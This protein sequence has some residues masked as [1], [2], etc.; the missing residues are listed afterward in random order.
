M[1]LLL[2][3]AL[4]T[5]VLCFFFLFSSFL[6]LPF[7]SS[8]SS[9][10]SSS[11]F[12]LPLLPPPFSSFLPHS[13]STPSSS[14]Q[15]LHLFLFFILSIPC[16]LCFMYAI[17][18]LS[19]SA[20]ISYGRDFFPL[21]YFF[22]SYFTFL[23]SCLVLFRFIFLFGSFAVIFIWSLSS[24]LSFRLSLTLTLTFLLSLLSSLYSPSILPS[25][26][27]SPP[28]ILISLHPSLS[29]FLGLLSLILVYYFSS[30]PLLFIISR[31]RKN[32]NTYF[33]FRVPSFPHSVYL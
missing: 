15:M 25:H 22:C 12:F 6:P 26:A 3:L 31:S 18:H 4:F 7:P 16:S 30:R 28:S 17:Y 33:C 27:P 10:T 9:T 21:F 24:E 2:S 1:V 20:L 19:Q 32:S 11:P 29:L 8:S 14:V 23:F 5:F 13:Q